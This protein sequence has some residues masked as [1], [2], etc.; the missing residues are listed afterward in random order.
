MTVID[1]LIDKIET[2]NEEQ[3]LKH[4]NAETYFEEHHDCI[5]TTIEG[6]NHTTLTVEFS[7]D[8]MKE[9]EVNNQF[10]NVLERNY[11][12]RINDF[13]VDETFTEL[14]SETFAEHNGFTARAFIEVLEDD[15]AHFEAIDYKQK[16]KWM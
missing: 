16:V 13:D 14:W 6:Y 2:F 4:G 15:K 5:F 7:M 1:E 9:M 11:R 12:E 8:D 3:D 10:Y